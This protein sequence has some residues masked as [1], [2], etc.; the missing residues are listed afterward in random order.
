MIWLHEDALRA[1]HPV[2]TGVGPDFS[3]WYIWDEAYLRRMDYGYKRLLFIYETL[4][5]LP[6]TIVRGGFLDCLPVLAARNGNVVRVPETPNPELI[7]TIERLSDDC[8]VQVIADTPFVTLSRDPDLGRF[9]RYWKIARE[10]A[11]LASGI[12]R[13]SEM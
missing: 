3:A 9:F 8:D 11:M 7:R 10:P 4:L 6:V 13:G 5:E 1:E 12:C 2:F